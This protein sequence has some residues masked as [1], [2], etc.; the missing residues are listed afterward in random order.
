M[1]RTQR[2]GGEHEPGAAEMIA[3]IQRKRR[4]REALLR[5]GVEEIGVAA[6]AVVEKTARGGERLARLGE[7]G[8]ELEHRGRAW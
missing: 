7:A 2:V 5:G 8:V 3:A 1:S 4:L 6:G